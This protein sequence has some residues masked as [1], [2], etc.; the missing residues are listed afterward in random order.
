MAAGDVAKG[1]CE[2]GFADVDWTDDSC[3]SV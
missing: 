1:V 3:H 2:K